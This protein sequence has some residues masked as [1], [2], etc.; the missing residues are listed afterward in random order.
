MLQHGAALVDDDGDDVETD[1]EVEVVTEEVPFSSEDQVAL[2]A[3]IHSGGGFATG[4][5]RAGFHFHDHQLV[6]IA[7]N[8]VDFVVLE[9][10][11]AF[12]DAHNPLR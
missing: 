8:D 1:F 11:V 3:E 7:G 6:A 9:T 12:E 4:I 5:A 2:L 10:P